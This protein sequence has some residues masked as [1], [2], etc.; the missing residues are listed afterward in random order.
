[1]I[2]L[3][4]VFTIVIW[5]ISM[6]DNFSNVANGLFNYLTGNFVWFYLITMTLF[7]VFCVWVALSKHGKIKLVKLDEEPEF[8]TGMGVELVFWGIAEPQNH[9]VSPLNMA[10]RTVET[11]NF[12]LKTLFFHCS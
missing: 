11:V 4:V 2:S 7:V 1:M 5:G 6:L 8:S 12:V 9:F 10:G 3:I